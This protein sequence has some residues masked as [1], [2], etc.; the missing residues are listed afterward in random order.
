MIAAEYRLTLASSSLKPRVEAWLQAKEKE[1]PGHVNQKVEE[2]NPHANGVS[3]F[4][5][6]VRQKTA[7]T[8]SMRHEWKS[9]TVVHLFFHWNNLASLPLA[10]LFFTGGHI[11]WVYVESPMDRQLKEPAEWFRGVV[12]RRQATKSQINKSSEWFL[13]ARHEGEAK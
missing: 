13:V 6:M 8:L 9:P 2:L 10:R 7:E 5:A 12:E 4:K 3:G 11:S 1:L